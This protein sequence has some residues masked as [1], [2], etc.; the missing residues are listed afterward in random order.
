[1]TLP[2]GQSPLI[3]ARVGIVCLVLTTR[4]ELG[5]D[6]SGGISAKVDGLRE[7]Q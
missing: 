4:V 3:V 7:A 6:R 2:L 1:M 5:A